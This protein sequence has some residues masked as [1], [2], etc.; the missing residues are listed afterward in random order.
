MGGGGKEG[1]AAARA[2][3]V[4]LLLA[5][6]TLL[7]LLLGA[8]TCASLC[9]LAGSKVGSGGFPPTTSPCPEAGKRGDFRGE[10][11]RP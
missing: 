4:L 5:H 7:L 10:T 11:P 9:N 2:D 6:K 3:R 1:T 8:N